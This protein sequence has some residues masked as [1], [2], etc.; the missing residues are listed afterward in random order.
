MGK[1][2]QIEVPDWVDE[3]DIKKIVKSY[4]EENLSDSVTKEEFARNSGINPEEIVEF[5]TEK[6]LKIL[7][8][9]RKEAKKRCQS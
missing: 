6:E 8:E 5:S 7:E 3:E 4:L 9:L 1:I 2:I